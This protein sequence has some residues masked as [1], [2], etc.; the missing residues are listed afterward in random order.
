MEGNVKEASVVGNAAPVYAIDTREK[1]D[2]K[3]QVEAVSVEETAHALL[4]QATL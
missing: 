1:H 2:A 3:I 4:C